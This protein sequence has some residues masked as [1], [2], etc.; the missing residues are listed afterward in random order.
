M[1]DE[2]RKSLF[3]GYGT[4][5]PLSIL[6]DYPD[7]ADRQIEIDYINGKWELTGIHKTEFR[8]GD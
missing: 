8:H 1:R 5:I 3:T 6:Q 4:L 7:Y 2:A